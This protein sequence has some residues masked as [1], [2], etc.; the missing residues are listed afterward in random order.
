[1][2]NFDRAMR[3]VLAH[4]GG[5][6]EN[7][8]DRGG[9]T[10][11]GIT[12][13]VL[14]NESWG[15]LDHDGDVDADDIRKLAE[16][17]AVAIYRRQ[18]WDRWGYVLLADDRVAGKVFDLAVNM[19]P[20][21]AHVLL[22]RACRSTGRPLTEDGILG[23]ITREA[24]N[25]A[26]Q[27]ALLAALRSEAAGFYRHIVARDASQMVFLKGWLRRAYDPEDFDR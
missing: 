4:E 25:S 6:S 11:Y 3:R 22:Q 16:W 23:P 27:D 18:W 14:A 9:P 15:D 17:D 20:H 8:A 1:M 7:P 26:P 19:G 12:V 5:Y 13:P 21:R 10:K 24:V 2:A